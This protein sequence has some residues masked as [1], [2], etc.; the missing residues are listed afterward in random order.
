MPGQTMNIG[1]REMTR[2]SVAGMI[3][4]HFQQTGTDLFGNKTGETAESSQFIADAAQVGKNVT[5]VPTDAAHPPV[6]ETAENVVT[7]PAQDERVDELIS[8][9]S[10]QMST[11]RRSGNEDL[12]NELKEILNKILGAAQRVHR[13]RKPKKE[14]NVLSR[15]KAD[16]GIQ[17]IK[18]VNIEWAGYT[19]NF[20]P[21]PAAMDRWLLAMAASGGANLYSVLK[22]SISLVGIDNEP[23]W[24]VLGIALDADYKQENSDALIRMPLYNRL[25]HACGFDIGF[26]EDKCAQCGALLNHYAMPLSL[27]LRCAD[28]IN[29]FFQ[30]DFGPYEQLEELYTLMRDAMPDR[31][32]DRGDIYPFLKVSQQQPE[33][34]NT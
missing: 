6:V 25:C 28:A 13:V 8:L 23:L 2:A 9:L 4:Q 3:N 27:R 22:I 14:S 11:A 1:G 15:L 21:P 32:N 19:W 16:L 18:S 10:D 5:A 17:R 26:E 12:A 33:T 34:T 20:A 7:P 29:S 24:K 31:I 30:D